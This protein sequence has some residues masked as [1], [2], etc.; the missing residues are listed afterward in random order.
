M[1]NHLV[2]DLSNCAPLYFIC[3][4]MMIKLKTWSVVVA[5]ERRVIHYLFKCSTLNDDFPDARCRCSGQKGG[6]SRSLGQAHDVVHNEAAILCDMCRTWVAPSYTVTRSVH[7]R[8]LYTPALAFGRVVNAIRTSHIYCT[9]IVHKR[10]H[11]Y[12]ATVLRRL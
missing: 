10:F 1:C 4:L 6:P 9:L 3:V 7:S 2:V 12:R 11:P 8:G 5:P